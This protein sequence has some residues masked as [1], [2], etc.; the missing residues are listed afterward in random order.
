MLADVLA[1]ELV[2]GALVDRRREIRDGVAEARVP[3]GERLEVA[4]EPKVDV[5]RLVPERAREGAGHGV[6]PLPVEVARLGVPVKFAGGEHEQHPVLGLVLAPVVNLL[7]DPLRPRGLRRCQQDE[8]TRRAEP[9]RD[10]GP[11]VGVRRQVRVVAKDV[12]GAQPVPGARQTVK[13][14]LKRDR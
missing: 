5:A 6:R 9:G 8:V 13:R 12:Q 3:Q 14:L 10:R 11:K 7:S 1:D 4:G 2:L